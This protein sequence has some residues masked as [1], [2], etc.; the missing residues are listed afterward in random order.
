MCRAIGS[1]EWA[2]IEK[3]FTAKERGEIAKL[4][5][6]FVTEVA[7]NHEALKKVLLVGTFG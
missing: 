6:G 1:L 7:R 2:K 4:D 5:P 3:I